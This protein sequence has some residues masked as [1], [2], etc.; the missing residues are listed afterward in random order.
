[1]TS[2][3]ALTPGTHTFDYSN[4]TFYYT[5]TVPGNAASIAYDFDH[6]H[7]IIHPPPWGVGLSMYRSAFSYLSHSLPL[8]FFEPRGNLRSSRPA[9]N[10]EMSPQLMVE[11]LEALRLHLGLKTMN[12]F[13]HSA[14]GS[15][16]LG[17]AIRHHERVGKL[18]LLGAA[19]LGF[20]KGPKREALEVEKEK[21][22]RRFR[23]E[24]ASQH[25]GAE[26]Y[27]RQLFEMCKLY[28]YNPDDGNHYGALREQ[29]T[30]KPDQWA[31][32]AYYGEGTGR[33]SWRQASELKSVTAKT[34]IMVGKE[35]KVCPLEES[36][37]L[38]R[39]IE[40]STLV[41]LEDCGHFPWVERKEDFRKEVKDFL[42]SS[43]LYEQR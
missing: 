23:A 33:T 15:I 43:A 36:Q 1:M 18:I 6:S 22:R 27:A 29:W 10:D 3:H 30:D 31:Y 21:V 12:L 20:D 9:K 34:L 7:L 32:E 11:D 41:V 13:G 25:E 5:V 8:I 26:N 38:A 19:L 35:E 2:S 28:L 42:I 40:K 4:L 24:D 14:G 39:G 16:V 17:Y 37:E